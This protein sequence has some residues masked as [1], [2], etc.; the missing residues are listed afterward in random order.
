[1]ARVGH[2]GRQASPSATHGSRHFRLIGP[3]PPPT[4]A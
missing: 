4:G 1:L 2:P 3:T